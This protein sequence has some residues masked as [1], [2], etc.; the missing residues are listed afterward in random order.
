MTRAGPAGQ[1]RRREAEGCCVPG[2]VTHRPPRSPWNTPGRLAR[3][4]GCAPT[5]PSAPT[6]SH[7]QLPCL[8]TFLCSWSPAREHRPSKCRERTRVWFLAAPR[9]A[10]SGRRSEC[11]VRPHGRARSAPAASTGHARVVSGRA[12]ATGRVQRPLTWGPG[13]RHE[14]RDR[15]RIG[16]E[17]GREGHAGNEAWTQEGAEAV[18]ERTPGASQGQRGRAFEMFVSFSTQNT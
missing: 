10:S 7:P 14:S 2:L 4:Q 3:A 18:A 11:P 17:E 12:N 13:P 15:T 9:C 6:H 1:R 16:R 5:A 8:P